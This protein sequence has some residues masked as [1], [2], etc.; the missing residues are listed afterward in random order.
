MSVTPTCHG[1]PMSATSAVTSGTRTRTPRRPAT[2]SAPSLGP[3]KGHLEQLSL[4]HHDSNDHESAGNDHDGIGLP[5]DERFLIDEA[6]RERG[7]AHI[8]ALRNQLANRA[9]RHS[10]ATDDADHTRAA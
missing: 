6:T 2:R 3:R 4:L 8:A 10:L 7:L 5:T 9:P 1:V